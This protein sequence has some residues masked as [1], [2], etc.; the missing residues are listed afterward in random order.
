MREI[1]EE[2]KTD[3]SIVQPDAIPCSELSHERSM[4]DDGDVSE[5]SDSWI[6]EC[7]ADDDFDVWVDTC[8]LVYDICDDG[9]KTEG[10]DRSARLIMRYFGARG[11]ATLLDEYV[12]L[13]ILEAYSSWCALSYRPDAGS[14][15]IAESLVAEGLPKAELTVLQ[16]RMAAHPSFYRID[17]CSPDAHTVEMT[18]LL[19][20]GSVLVHDD[21]LAENYEPGMCVTVRV[22]RVGGFWM[23]EM[24]GPPMGEK[25]AATACDFLREHGV[26]ITAEGLKR[27]AHVFGWLWTWMHDMYAVAEQVKHM[28]ASQG[29]LPGASQR[30]QTAS[31]LRSIDDW[32]YERTDDRHSSAMSSKIGA[33][34]PCPY[35]SGK[36]YKKCCGRKA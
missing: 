14:R 16:A 36:K 19:L 26:E 1:M 23:S 29:D 13:G 18:D 27:D 25:M 17:V 22:F 5:D 3:R 33:N 6:D 34:A 9:V 30:A 31:G 11:D 20:G 2:K 35:G 28:Q 7:L 21:I 4:H 24:A 32:E 12:D 10:W 15:T 8:E